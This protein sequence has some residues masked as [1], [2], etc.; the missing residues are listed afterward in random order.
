MYRPNPL[1]RRWVKASVLVG[2]W[3]LTALIYIASNTII[4]LTVEVEP[5]EAS[6]QAFDVG[7]ALWTLL[8]WYTWIPSTLIVLWLVRR[9]PLDRGRLV[10]NVLV[11]VIA[12]PA[13]SLFASLLFTAM[14][15]VPMLVSGEAVGAWFP[16][17]LLGTFVR[18]VRLDAFIYLTLLV[19]VHA[20]EYYRKYRERELQA[21]QLETELAEARLHALRLQLQP[22]FLFNTFHT[23]AMLVRQQRDEEAIE[24]ITVLSDFLRY[25]LDNTGAQEVSLR[26]ELDF[27]ESYLAIERIRFKNRLD[28]R[29]D[30]EDA[31]LDAQVP[32]LILQPLVENAVRHGI[33]PAHRPGRIEVVARREGDRLRLRVQDGGVGL[34]AGWSLDTHG[35]V[36][37]T[38]TK[39]RLERLYGAA[40]H[41][42]FSN[43]PGGGLTVTIVIPYRTVREKGD[44]ARE[45]AVLTAGEP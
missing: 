37:L 6:G 12:A 41:L 24:T 33:E 19:G 14:R 23:I 7:R 11:H 40:H 30:V 10:P 39:A 45:P 20:F 22:H 4:Y 31:A 28:I 27:L 16:D 36:G 29:I 21:A 35:G 18:S 25:V 44:P 13:V 8:A 42:A 2:F 1:E 26:Q 3:T 9:F 34:P 38:N 43:A 15:S 17:T 5:V 32:N